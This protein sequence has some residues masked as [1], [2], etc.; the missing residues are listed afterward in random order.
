MAVADKKDIDFTELERELEAAIDQDTRYWLQNDAK[1][2]AVNQ[3]VA[4]YDEFRDIVKAAHL[5][6]L[7]KK[8]ISGSGSND[9]SSSRGSFVWNS[10]ASGKKK[11]AAERQEKHDM[12]ND[13]YPRS[14]SNQ[15]DLQRALSSTSEFMQMWRS[16]DGSER[17]YAALQRVGTGALG[18]LFSTTEIPVG[19]LGEILEAAL[20]FRASTH[21]ICFVV[22]MLETLTK[23]KRFCLT[24]EFLS[25]GEKATCKQLLSK[26]NNSLQGQQQ[27]LAERGVT[28]WTLRQLHN[29]YRV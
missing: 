16:L 4:T 3:R 10:I 24:L 15:V 19:L 23:A 2:R 11:P 26:L 13:V 14:A 6:P 18:R 9:S 7:K 25:S 20:H 12:E 27:D 22:K 8:D 1:I 5:K 28:E 21:E 29:A 17:R